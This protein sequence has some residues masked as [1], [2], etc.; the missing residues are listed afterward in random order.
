M[1]NAAGDAAVEDTLQAGA[2]M[3]GHGD[4][5]SFLFL[6]GVDDGVDRVAALDQSSTVKPFLAKAAE[7]RLR[8]FSP[9]C[10]ASCTDF[11]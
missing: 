11:Q 9:S 10:S 5:I 4:E 8:Y 7:R 1:E 3:A 6:G 2:A